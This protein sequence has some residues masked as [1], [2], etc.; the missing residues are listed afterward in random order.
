[1]VASGI[2]MPRALAGEQLIN[3]VAA[4]KPLFSNRRP[5][6]ETARDYI[7][8]RSTPSHKAGAPPPHCSLICAIKRPLPQEAP[9]LTTTTRRFAA[10]Y[11]FLGLAG[12]EE[13][14]PTVRS[15]SADTP[16]SLTR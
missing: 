10:A 4:K 12:S 2:W 11:G 14:L 15:L 8:S 7:A 5:D 3:P 1:M 9:A 16:I 6:I 13:P